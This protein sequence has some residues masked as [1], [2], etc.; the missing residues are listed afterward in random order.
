LLYTLVVRDIKKKYRRSI[1]GV[2][3]SMLNPLLMMIITAMVFST[4]FRFAIENYVLY[5]LVGQ[6]VFTFFAEST[7]FAMGSILENSS[8]IKKV[9]VPKYLFPFSRVFSSCVNLL[10]TIPAILIMMLYTGQ[11]P[12]WRIVTFIVPLLLML[13]FCLGIGLI[14]SACVV[15]FR[16]I[17]HLYGI[18]LTALSYATPVFYPEDI[19]P[20]AYRFLLDY[21]P[22]YYFVRGF[23][24]VLYTGGVPTQETLLLCS[25]MAFLA[26][27]AG[28][29]VFHKAQDR[30][31]LYV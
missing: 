31:I 23:R 15:Y 5:L 10:F 30:F 17:F 2:L 4:L 24:E 1:L 11:I 7:N 29:L 9:Y 13:L 14:L 22:L 8:L 16:D 18:V 28:V 26:L 21:N 3:W 6:V 25:I 19:V 20:S 27:A 12:T